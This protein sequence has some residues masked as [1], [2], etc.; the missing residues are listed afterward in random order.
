MDMS[1]TSLSSWM[2]SMDGSSKMSCSKLQVITPTEFRS[3]KDPD[4]SQQAESSSPPTVS[5]LIAALKRRI[6][7]S[8]IGQEK[9]GVFAESEEGLIQCLKQREDKLV[10][11]GHEAH[12]CRDMRHY[13]TESA[14]FAEEYFLRTLN[15]NI[16]FIGIDYWLTIVVG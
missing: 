11:L 9:G 5:Q 2:T 15:T 4:N 7:V 10:E 13:V 3:N 1:R 16:S 8:Y 14:H 6:E 12:W